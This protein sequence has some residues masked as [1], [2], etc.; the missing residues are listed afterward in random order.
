MTQQVWIECQTV[1]QIFFFI[2]ENQ[3]TDFKALAFCL[4]QKN[5]VLSLQTLLK[6]TIK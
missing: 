3:V 1:T 4:G 5:A 6:G 2:G